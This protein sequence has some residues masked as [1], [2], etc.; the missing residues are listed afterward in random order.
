MR[1]TSADVELASHL[2]IAPADR[3]CLRQ[4]SGTGLL[5]SLT[6]ALATIERHGP[7]TPSS[8]PCANASSTRR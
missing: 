8:S 1:S 5:P 2:R 3:A 4:E 6:A 7:L